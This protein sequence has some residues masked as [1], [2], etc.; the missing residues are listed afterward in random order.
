MYKPSSSAP[1]TQTAAPQHVNQNVTYVEVAVFAPLV[2][3]FTYLWPDCLGQIITGIRIQ[4]P[5]GKGKRIGVVINYTTAE[6]DD[7]NRYKSVWD[8]LD[9]S[10]LL[11]QAR[12]KWLQR[13]GRYYLAQ[14]G[15]LWS[16]ALGWATQHDTRRFRCPEPSKL[17]QYSSLLADHFPNRAAISLKTII[18]RCKDDIGIRHSISQACAKG[19][20]EE[21][22]HDPLWLKVEQNRE[23]ESYNPPAP[24]PTDDQ[25]HA[26]TSITASLGKFQPFLLFGCT[27][28]GKTEVYLKASE[29]VI[30]VGG[31]VLVLVPEIGLTPLWLSRLKQRFRRVA[32]WHSAM[33]ARE[34][35]QVRQHLQD[36]DILI[37]TRSALFLPLPKLALIVVDEEHDASFKQQEGMTY[38][39]RDMG[40]LLAQEFN[41]P[42]VLGSAT[43]SLE[44]WRQVT[45]GAYHRL[46]LPQRIAPNK[47][48]IASKVID[49]RQEEGPVSTSLFTALQ[50]TLV[51][52]EQSILFL[53]RRGYSPALQCTACGDVPEC[54]ACSM[55]LTLHRRA[56]QLRC[57]SCGF[58]RRVPQTCESC[59]EVAFMPL[60]EGTEKLEEWLTEKL[61]DLRFS[62]FD[63]DVITSHARLEKTL[64]EF[65]QGEL[66]CLIG[67]Q[68]LVKGHD[69]PNVTLVGVINA[70]LGISMPDFRAGERWWQQMTQVTGR[71]GRGEKAGQVIIQT[72]MP[73]AEWFQRIS[74]SQAESTMNDELQL[75]EMLRF[76]PFARWVRIVFSARKLERANQVAMQCA[77]SCAALEGISISGPMPCP[78]ERVAGQYRIEVLLRDP[79]RKLLPWKLKSILSAMPTSRDVRIRIDVDPQ[80]MM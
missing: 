5:F 49:M 33:T 19:W 28:S 39:A 3:T 10:P 61:P 77:S 54:H 14:P 80:D 60:G 15:E 58:R 40:V 59:G 18:Q 34:R 78:M 69:F 22:G 71:A 65:E 38:S 8:R 29:T 16:S 79:S 41:I 73:E 52:K 62:R 46:N 9:D 47:A 32:L 4:V 30:A 72:R 20:L 50:D 42:I 6:P 74:E 76:P 26:I 64:T 44:S 43:P 31:Q 45:D 56:G 25:H 36:T 12:R 2:G 17:R 67:T 53:N 68:M 55:R 13:V 48:P 35:L 70:D 66:D 23:Q 21:V 11:D 24:V 27:G 63:R 7:E 57:H 37:G 75:R 51:K 1:A